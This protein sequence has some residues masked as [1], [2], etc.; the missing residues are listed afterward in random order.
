MGKISSELLAVQTIWGLVEPKFM[1]EGI[2]VAPGHL[3][4]AMMSMFQDYS[5]WMIVLFDNIL[6]LAHDQEDFMNKFNLFIKRC[7]K[8]NIILK[9]TKKSISLT[10]IVNTRLSFLELTFEKCLIYCISH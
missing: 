4:H 7:T 3:Q 8:H 5:E 9:S 1:P 2:S 10:Y 6:L